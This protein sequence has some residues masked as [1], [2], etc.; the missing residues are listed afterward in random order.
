MSVERPRGAEVAS[1][2]AT[3]FVADA[4]R[5]GHTIMVSKQLRKLVGDKPTTILPEIVFGILAVA[6]QQNELIVS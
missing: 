2:S 5:Q 6:I 3:L 4:C 1:S